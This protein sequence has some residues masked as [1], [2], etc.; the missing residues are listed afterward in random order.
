MML[1]KKK[2]NLKI[3]RL[4]IQMVLLILIIV[5]MAEFISVSF[6]IMNLLKRLNIS[7][8]NENIQLFMVKIV[9]INISM[10]LL[11][12]LIVMLVSRIFKK[13]QSILNLRSQSQ[14]LLKILI[15]RLKTLYF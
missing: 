10:I 14:W 13:M 6:I 15:K 5:A 12:G 11:F 3:N 4:P 9:F 2:L 7:P 8:D 1:L